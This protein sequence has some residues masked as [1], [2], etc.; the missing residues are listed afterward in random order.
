MTCHSHSLRHSLT[1]SLT[2]SALLVPTRLQTCPPTF[3]TCPPAFLT[4]PLQVTEGINA[5]SVTRHRHMPEIEQGLAD[6]CGQDV[7]VRCADAI[8]ALVGSSLAP[9]EAAAKWGLPDYV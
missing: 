8:H 2:T 1:S 3:Q 4:S 6:A 7:R 5:Y 9:M